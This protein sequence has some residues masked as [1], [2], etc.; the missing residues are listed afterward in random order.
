MR[1]V[2]SKYSPTMIV[3]LSKAGALEAG[4]FA[5]YRSNE[6]DVPIKKF[7]ESCAKRG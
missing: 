4:M 7:A 6:M 3:S 5:R 1:I 2:L